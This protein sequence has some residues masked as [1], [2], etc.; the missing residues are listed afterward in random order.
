[1]QFIFYIFTTGQ[2]WVKIKSVRT[3]RP[4]FISCEF[5]RSFTKFSNVTRYIIILAILL[6]FILFFHRFFHF[7]LKFL[8][9]HCIPKIS[10]Y[11]PVYTTDN[12]I[13]IVFNY[14]C[15]EHA[16]ILSSIYLWIIKY[17]VFFL[18]SCYNCKVLP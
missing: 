9:G 1:M 16:R 8:L 6:L 12:K 5:L 13:P 2:R 17:L 14:P 7:H 3:C 10:E 18:L 4:G 15:Y 11:F